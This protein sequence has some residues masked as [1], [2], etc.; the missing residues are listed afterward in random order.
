MNKRNIQ[1]IVFFDLDGTLHQQD[2]FGCFL[3]YLLFRLPLN[4]ILVTLVLPVVLSGLLIR[5]VLIRWPI[6]LLLWS[7]T[8]GHSEAQLQR[9]QE[10]FVIMFRFRLHRF[11]QVMAHLNSYLNKK[12][13]QVWIITGSPQLLVEKVYSDMFFFSKIRL[14]G[15][16]IQWRY[17]GWI[18]TLR[19][20]GNEKVTQLERILGVPLKLYSGYSDS[21]RDA[22]L[23][24]FCQNRWHVTHDGQLK[25]LN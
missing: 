3:L 23:L 14:I 22:P 10:K 19:C 8:F 17:G 4:I 9:L 12:H 13:T 15:S 6:S 25:R 2:M 11:P 16:Q 21:S 1:R 20:L 18:M 5:G 24:R 7:I